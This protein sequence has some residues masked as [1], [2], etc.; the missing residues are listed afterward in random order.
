M[1]KSPCLAFVRLVCGPYCGSVVPVAVLPF[2]PSGKAKEKLCCD[3]ESNS[4][5][6]RTKGLHGHFKMAP[7]EQQQFHLGVSTAGNRTHKLNDSDTMQNA[8]S[9][10]LRVV[11]D[12]SAFF[13]TVEPFTLPAF[14]SSG[15]YLTIV[16]CS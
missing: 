6:S 15:R 2:F 8:T 13:D 1:A 7:S 3:W 16:R 5:D 14:E 11:E 12:K 4:S 10:V 9:R